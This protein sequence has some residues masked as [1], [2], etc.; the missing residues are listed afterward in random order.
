MLEADQIGAVCIESFKQIAGPDNL[1]IDSLREPA[2]RPVG[3][4]LEQVLGGVGQ[5]AQRT[6]G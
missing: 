1:E 4:R 2:A 3:E 5:A 6:G